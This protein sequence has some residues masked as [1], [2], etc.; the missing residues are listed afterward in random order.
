MLPRAAI[1]LALAISIGLLGTPALAR[2]DP[3]KMYAK[4]QDKREKEWIKLQ[5]KQARAWD[6]YER[7]QAKYDRRMYGY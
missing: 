2:P 4:Q 5:R 6:K 1:P 3:M 7:K